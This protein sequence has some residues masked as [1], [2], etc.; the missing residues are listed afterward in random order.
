MSRFWLPLLGLLLAS[1]GNRP[2]STAYFTSVTGLTLCS[3][4]SVR[5]VNANAPD[6]SPGFDSIYVVDVTMPEPCIAPF[7]KAVG[8]R[9]GAR[10]EPSQGCS[11]NA[12]GGD[13]YSIEPHPAGFRVTHS[14]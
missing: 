8:E 4:A 10:C 6:R 2:E 9:I 7:A 5:N 11:G 13:F 14:T 3:G 12:K 1:C